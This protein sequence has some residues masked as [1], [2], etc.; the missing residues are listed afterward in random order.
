MQL[1]VHLEDEQF[2]LFDE[3]DADAVE[4][5]PKTQ[6]TAFFEANER[7]PE[8]RSTVYPDFPTKFTWHRDRR[9]WLPRKGV[10]TSGRMVFVPPNAGEK[11][12][13]R[14]LLSVVTDVRSFTQ[15]K[16]VDGVPHLTYRGVCLAR[17]LLADDN[18]WKSALE[19]GRYMHTGPRLCQ[20]FV[21]IVANNQPSQPALLWDLFKT[22]LCDDLR[23]LLSHRTTQTLSDDSIFDYGLHLIQTRLQQDDKTMD[24]VRLPKPA[25]N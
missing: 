14:L 20:L 12:Y 1:P 18:K 3:N 7:Y 15:L 11:F 10:R 8:A 21:A 4:R 13:A 19:D 24:T 17:G 25:R 5:P 23:R 16:T 2:V 9:Q 6:L 22:H